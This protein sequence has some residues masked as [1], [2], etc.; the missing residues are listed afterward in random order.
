MEN[1]YRFSKK[2][3]SDEF[4]GTQYKKSQ[5]KENAYGSQTYCNVAI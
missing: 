3:K 1:R 4:V 2:E 5:A